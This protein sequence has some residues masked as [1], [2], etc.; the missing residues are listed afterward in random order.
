MIHHLQVQKYTHLAQFTTSLNCIS[1]LAVEIQI[2]NLLKFI[3]KVQQTHSL[4]SSFHLLIVQYPPSTCSM[5]TR[6]SHHN[7]E[8]NLRKQRLHNQQW[9]LCRS[10]TNLMP[11]NHYHPTEMV[12]CLMKTQGLEHWLAS[13][14]LQQPMNCYQIMTCLRY[15]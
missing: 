7:N 3:R 13:C 6:A 9:K 2:K 14:S 10:Q 12:Y 11:I 1:K 5:V 4:G 15:Q 8:N